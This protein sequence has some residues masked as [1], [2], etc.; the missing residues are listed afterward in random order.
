MNPNINILSEKTL[1]K[2][3]STLKEYTLEYTKKDAEKEIQI[4]EIY[5]SGDGAAILLFNPDEKKI[6]MVRQFRLPAYL[7]GHP[8]GMMVEACAGMLDMKDP[9]GA[10]IKEV[11]E[12]TGIRLTE[13]RKVFEAFATPGAH[14]EKIHFFIAVYNDAMK[15][16][17]GGGLDEESEEIEVLEISFSEAKQWLKEGSIVDVKTIALLQFGILHDFIS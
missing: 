16:H 11:E 15:I 13:V 5:D 9:E 1:Y 3:W 14:K 12:E 17:G 7:N 10:I 8:D 2:G 4:R 6:I